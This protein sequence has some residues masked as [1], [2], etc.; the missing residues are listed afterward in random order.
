MT[1]EDKSQR[2]VGIY[3]RPASADRRWQRWLPFAV[4]AVVSLAWIAYL[5][6]TR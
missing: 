6:L 1:A 3:E 4:A 2:K 5:L